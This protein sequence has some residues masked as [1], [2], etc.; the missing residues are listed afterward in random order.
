MS[1]ASNVPRPL[2]PLLYLAWADGILTPAE[3]RLIHDRC[4]ALDDA[5]PDLCKR[6]KAWT[7]PSDPPSATQYFRWV[8]ALQTAADDIPQA[9]A[10]SLTELAQALATNGDLPDATARALADIEAA[11]GVDSR[12]VLGDLLGHRSADTPPPDAPDLPFAV[13]QLQ[14][15]LDGD[16]AEIK[17]RLRTLLNDP[18]LHPDPSLPTPAYREAVLDV[19]K[20]LA[21]QGLGALSYP[22]AY[23]GRG[24]IGAFITTFAMLAYGDLSVVVKYGVQFGLFGG[25]LQQLGTQRHHETYLERAGTLDLPGCFAMSETGHGS[26]VRDLQTTARYDPSDETFI[27]HTPH[28]SA[29]KDWIGNAAAHGQLATVFAQLETEGTTYGVHAFLVPIRTADGAP[30]P[31]VRIED[32]GEKMGLNGVDNGRLWFDQVRIPRANLLDRYATVH[33]DGSYESPIPSAGRRFFTM[34]STLVG[35]R[36]SVARAGLNAAKKG[37]TIAIRYGNTRRQFGPKDRSEVRILDYRTHQRRLLPPLATSYAL[38]MALEDLTERFAAR[39]AGANLS[40][41]E[42]TANALKAYATWHTTHTLQTAREACGGQGY[43]AENQIAQL[44]ADTDVFT[45]FEGDNTVLMLQVAKGLL[46][47]FQREFRDLNVL[48]MMRFVA[49]EVTTR[50]T[51]MNPI[52]KR[53]TDTEHL[54]EADMQGDALRFRERAL[55]QSAAQRLKHRMDNGA[56]PFD[57]F[58]EVQD[59][60]LTLAHAHAERVVFE[61]FVDRIATV[62]D[63]S[64]RSVLNTIRC[65]YGLHRL[66]AHRAWFLEKGY[67][68]APKSKA[69]RTEVNT[70]C[71]EI[72][73]WARALTDA[74]Q[75]PSGALQ[76]PIA[77]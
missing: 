47:D 75:I 51:E 60:L 34:L 56:A 53:A 33:P 20:R 73:P 1:S 63:A 31:G 74:W 39:A 22:K 40:D 43:L 54:R 57:A 18:A 69:I 9:T 26:N 12:E 59:H 2:L 52:V 67:F 70:L 14:A 68:E 38:H 13:E 50:V 28:D 61:R 41:I 30:A 21:A 44:K 48:G 77:Q 15:V 72:R 66:E 11:L 16:R 49:G 32:C 42:A 58:V 65:L 4:A 35:G 36:I 62:E 8:R 27:L 29:R 7:D 37:L 46:S 64:S 23:G 76:A 17:D 55:V 3:Q 10:R 6:L 5:A 71:G 24:D 19:C 45:T 25:S